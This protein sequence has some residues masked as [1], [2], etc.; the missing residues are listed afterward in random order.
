MIVL[1][2]P[3]LAQLAVVAAMIGE[4]GRVYPVLPRAANAAV[5]HSCKYRRLPALAT[6]N[7]PSVHPRK[8]TR[9]D[10]RARPA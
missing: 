2:R 5:N 4:H 10:N 3:Q 1:E 6:K 8:R 9:R 7:S